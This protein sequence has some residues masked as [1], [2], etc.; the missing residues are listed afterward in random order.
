MDYAE[1]LEIEFTGKGRKRLGFITKLLKKG[2][3]SVEWH[4]MDCA[5]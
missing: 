2:M 4:I 5:P 1:L 3:S